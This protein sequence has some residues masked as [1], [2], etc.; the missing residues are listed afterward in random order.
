MGQIKNIKL[1]IVTDI[2]TSMREEMS[3]IYV[4][5]LDH[6]VTDPDLYDSFDKFGVIESVTIIKDRET[7]DSR[8]FGFVKFESESSADKAIGAGSSEKGIKVKGELCTVELPRPKPMDDGFRGGSRGRG[9]DRERGGRGGYR[10]GRGG[11]GYDRRESFD[12]Y[13]SYRPRGGGRGRGRGRF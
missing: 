1:H 2:K 7:G 8:G 11:G 6:K 3:K 9:Y 5:G 10:G 13:D 4:G 12:S